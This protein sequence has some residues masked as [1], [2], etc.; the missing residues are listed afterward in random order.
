MS[1]RTITEEYLG[2]LE[3]FHQESRRVNEMT[4]ELSFRPSLN[5]Y[6]T[7]LMKEF[8]EDIASV[9]EP[10][11]QAK[12]GRPDWRF[13]NKRSLGIY[14]YVE[15]KAFT[16]DTRIRVE[17]YIEQVKKY[18]T[19][20]Y[21]VIL[22]DGIEFIFFDPA[23]GSHKSLLLAEKGVSGSFTDRLSPDLALVETEF[24]KFFG[25]IS[26]RRI[27]EQQLVTE[28]AMRARFL[29]D[30]IEALADLRPGAGLNEIENEAISIL[31]QLKDIVQKHHDPLLRDKK[32]FSAFVSQVLIFGLIYAHRVLG[33]ERLEPSERYKKMKDFWLG[34]RETHYTA[35]LKPFRALTELLRAE[36]ASVGALG[37]WYEDS[38]LMLS[39]VELREEQINTPDYH[40]LFERFLGAFD[41][42]TRFDYGAF[43]TPKELAAYTVAL[44]E[45]INGRE[46]QGS[47][48]A[49]GNR[50]IDPCCGTGSFLERLLTASVRSGGNASIIGFEIL[51]APYALAH[52]R[53]AKVSPDYPNMNIVLTNTLSDVL[54]GGPSGGAQANL[55]EDEQQTAREL[56]RPPLTLIIGNPPSSDSF[57]HSNGADFTIIQNLLNDFRPPLDARQP[58]QNTQ[59]QLQN[60]FVK[61]LRWTGYKAVKTGN[62]IVA[63]VLPS[64]FAESPSYKYARKWFVDNFDMFWV[65][66][67]DKD[68]RTGVRSSSVFHTLQG[69]LLFV[70]LRRSVRQTNESSKYHYVSIA[71]FNIDEKN[72]FFEIETE[73]GEPMLQNFEAFELDKDE[74]V[75]R[76]QKEF[77]RELYSNFWSLYKTTEDDNRYIFD[78]HC[79]GLKLAPSSLFV[80]ADEPVLFRRSGDIANEEVGV[81]DLLSKWY[82]GQD[83]PPS[84]TKFSTTVRTAFR[85][86]LRRNSEQPAVM[87]SYRPM[88]N[89]PAM[90]SEDILRTLQRA[91]GGGTRYRPEIVSAYKD[92]RTF[93]IAI[94]PSPKD[95]GE[96]LQRFAS[97]CWYLPDNDLSKRGNAHVFCNYFPEYKQKGNWDDTP[98]LNISREFMTAVGEE[99][100]DK[101]IFYV[102]GVLCS[103]VYLDAFEP[104]LFTP[105]GATQ[106]PRIPM[107]RSKEI[108]DR[109]AV[110]G[111]ELALLE[112]HTSDS[113]MFLEDTY[114]KFL[115]SYPGEFKM[116][117]FE[118]N[119]EDE[120]LLLKG[121]EV[122]MEIKP[123]PKDILE[124]NIGGYQALQ[125]WLKMHSFQYT[126]TNFSKP[127]FKRLLFMLQSIGKQIGL[128]NTLNENVSKIL[129]REEVV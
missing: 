40:D 19:L 29:A 9:Y 73:A 99:V 2:A 83:R 62:S 125:Q 85:D 52:Y 76:P 47:I 97:F 111:E 39:H 14:G 13:Y 24:R 104:V 56:A 109:I 81:S 16:E 55:F 101:V 107:P 90:I 113:D 60:E 7:E 27:S 95:L 35:H 6:F 63:L 74:P 48:Y 58:R 20:G 87:Y 112:R 91:P 45:E 25:T 117:D 61:F 79:S 86:V 71:D 65:V 80:H 42:K 32:V 38:C 10:K 94:A 102:Y 78:R 116:T 110:L 103:D 53:I 96:K 59:K 28:C 121:D 8:G 49:E 21:R 3:E 46:F 127:H 33:I 82:K 15:A 124:F 93:G 75:F 26:A 122:R 123:I 126:R 118:I 50:L 84:T 115:S 5:N 1:F 17:D 12:A 105:S 34:E 41:P 77:D 51:P 68:G 129:A 119:P 54:E 120:S 23:N 92:K 69:R 64:S 18:L 67:I 114:E 4:G 70:A 100:P 37:V 98:R 108:F 22:S 66:D 57:S 31:A 89:L 106:Q 72:A 44:V 128:V 36:I 43:Y 30:E 11:Q 88:L